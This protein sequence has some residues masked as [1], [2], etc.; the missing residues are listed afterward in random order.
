MDDDLA[1]KEFDLLI[2][3]TQLAI[4]RADPGFAALR[5]KIVAIAGLLE[6]ISNVP[7]VAKEL[8]LILAIQTED[9]WQDIASPTLETVRRR[10]RALIKLIEIKRRPIVYTDFEDEIGASAEIAIRGVNVGTD[11]DRFRAKARYFLK[12]NANKIAVLKLRRDEP[13]TQTDLAELERIFV[14]S[15]ADPAQIEAV[16]SEGGLGLFVRSLVGLDREAAK[17]AFADFLAARKPSADQ[18]EFVNMIVDHLTDRGVMEPRL[19]YESPFT[20]INPLGVEGIFGQKD[21]AEVVSIIDSVN[22]RAAA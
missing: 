2:L 8:D 21:A 14:A 13:L 12:E 19:L 7:M 16:R 11:M 6:E 17:K 9:F 15:G 22:R 20:D 1:A 10:L 5:D 4:L 18:I 3:R